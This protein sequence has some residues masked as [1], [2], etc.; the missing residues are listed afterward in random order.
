[1]R[2]EKYQWVIRAELDH[3]CVRQKYT[4]PIRGWEKNHMKGHEVAIKNVLFIF[5]SQKSPSRIFIL[6]KSQYLG[7]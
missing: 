6:I 3:F 2:S 4:S 1:M 5:P 7:I